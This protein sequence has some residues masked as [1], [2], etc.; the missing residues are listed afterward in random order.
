MTH[1]SEPS[2][3]RGHALWEPLRKGRAAR[4]GP[5]TGRP[6]P[7]LGSTAD[8]RSLPDIKNPATENKDALI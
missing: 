1:H 4:G 3:S 8:P 2:I 6:R 7:P 5:E